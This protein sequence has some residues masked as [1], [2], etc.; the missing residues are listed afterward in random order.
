[1]LPAR[2]SRGLET[3]ADGRTASEMVPEFRTLVMSAELAIILK[4]RLS[5]VD[6]LGRMEQ[7]I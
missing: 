4:L 6:S 2:M 3:L 5:D 1:M 7:M